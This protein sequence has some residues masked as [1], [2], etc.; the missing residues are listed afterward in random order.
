M[1]IDKLTAK[2]GRIALRRSSGRSSG[3]WITVNLALLAFRHLPADQGRRLRALA[4]ELARQPRH[5]RRLDEIRRIVGDL[6]A[7]ARTFGARMS[8][9]MMAERAARRKLVQT[10]Q[11]VLREDEDDPWNR[12]VETRGLLG[13]DGQEVWA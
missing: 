1:N 2:A 7:K 13:L 8:E 11:D 3:R 5:V 12:L 6:L 9:R 4:D 10:W